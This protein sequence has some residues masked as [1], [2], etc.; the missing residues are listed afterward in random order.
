VRELGSARNGTRDKQRRANQRRPVSQRGV[1]A[2]LA[3]SAQEDCR[4][5]VGDEGDRHAE[6]Q[7]EAGQ[8]AE[9]VERITAEAVIDVVDK[10]EERVGADDRNVSEASASSS[11][12]STKASAQYR[13]NK[14]RN[15][16]R[17]PING[18]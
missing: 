7:D 9:D 5:Q 2:E 1:D 18:N 10:R 12:A 4:W 15:G 8:V 11:A 17:R 3:R 13:Q 6:G 14:E 16:R